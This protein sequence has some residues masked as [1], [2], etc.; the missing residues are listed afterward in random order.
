MMERDF[1]ITEAL[2]E[3]FLVLE[4]SSDD[5]IQPD[6]AVRAMENI[7]SSLL[8]MA[9]ADQVDLRQRMTAIGENSDDHSYRQFASSLPDMIGLAE[10]E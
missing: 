9:P 3:A 2:I 10:V 8:S 1:A 7:S 5:E 6:I 4:N